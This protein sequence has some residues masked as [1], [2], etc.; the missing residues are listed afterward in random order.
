MLII[1]S[2]EIPLTHGIGIISF[3]DS[4]GATGSSG[5]ES[6]NEFETDPDNTPSI[7]IGVLCLFVFFTMVLCFV[8]SASQQDR[9]DYIAMNSGTMTRSR[10]SSFI[11]FLSSCC[12]HART[13]Q[14]IMH[15]ENTSS[16][17]AVEP[18]HADQYQP[19]QQI[20]HEP[21]PLIVDITNHLLQYDDC[22]TENMLR[23]KSNPLA[24]S[25]IELTVPMRKSPKDEQN[26]PLP[27]TQVRFHLNPS[28]PPLPHTLH[29]R[30][31][32]DPLP[33]PLVERES[34][35]NLKSSNPP[36]EQSNLNPP[37]EIHSSYGP[38]PS[39]NDPH[40]RRKRVDEVESIAPLSVPM[41]NRSL[42]RELLRQHSQPHVIHEDYN[43]DSNHHHPHRHQH[44]PSN[45]EI[46]LPPSSS[47]PLHRMTSRSPCGSSSTSP[48]GRSVPRVKEG[49]FQFHFP[50]I[51]PRISPLDRHRSLNPPL[52]TT[53]ARRQSLS[54]V[55]SPDHN[56]PPQPS[57]HRSSHSMPETRSPSS[58]NQLTRL[59][60]VKNTQVAHDE[61]SMRIP[62]ASP[63]LQSP[64]LMPNFHESPQASP[65]IAEDDIV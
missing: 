60:E 19:S 17:A 57:Y 45:H 48:T 61:H 42:A 53:H 10:L 64:I 15:D 16:I 52:W 11:K 14:P 32:S 13:Q 4:L 49:T 28:I 22:T 56:N 55:H 65:P 12:I 29:R 38:Q 63:P 8:I 20:C 24:S 34:D 47:Y 43:N 2:I 62:S 33:R 3:Q 9:V 51:T 1:L 25:E 36:T 7:V 5:S 26:P 41:S 39:N 21:P 30:Q 50:V 27:S 40:T 37:P 58:P 35:E 23:H 46:N 59:S 54:Q 18:T 44:H 6:G 31:S